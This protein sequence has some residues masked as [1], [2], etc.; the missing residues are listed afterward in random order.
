L[1]GFTMTD[2]RTEKARLADDLEA[3]R[4]M[5]SEAPRPICDIAGDTL[6]RAIAA[7]EAHMPDGEVEVF[8]MW[9]VQKC[10]RHG[11]WKTD[12]RSLGADKDDVKFSWDCMNGGALDSLSTLGLA[13]TVRVTV[14]APAGEE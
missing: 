5:V 13:R 3:L 8:E 12:L 10:N 6:A 4:V 11:G 9:A 7:V 14:T 1:E 2:T